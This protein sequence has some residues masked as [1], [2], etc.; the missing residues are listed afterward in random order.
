MKSLIERL[1]H[2][3]AQGHHS[4]VLAK[5]FARAA[6][7]TALWLGLS[8]TVIASIDVIRWASAAQNEFE[9]RDA[10]RIAFE[11]AERCSRQ[12][13]KA[14]THEHL[15]CMMDRNAKRTE[16]PAPLGLSMELP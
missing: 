1:L 3:R 10:Q 11:N 15:L 16:R 14:G 2:C 9:L 12:G 7:E 6:T 4:R 8:A 5:R 13:L